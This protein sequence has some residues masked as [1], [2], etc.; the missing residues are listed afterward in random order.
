MLI[1]HQG[2][3]QVID[4]KIDILVQQY[5]QF[6]ISEDESIDGAFARFNTII[7]SLKA[8][9]EG[10]SSKNCVRKFLWA[11]HPKWRAKVTAIEESKS[12]ALKA[13]KES[14]DEVCSTS[15]SEDE[16]YAIAC[17]DPNHLIGECLKPLKDKNQRAFIGGSW[18]DSGEEDDEKIKDETCLVAQAPSETPKFGW[19]S[20]KEQRIQSQNL[21]IT[22]LKNRVKTLEDNEKTREGFAQEDAPNTG[23]GGVDQGEDLIVVNVE[24][25]NEKSTEKGSDSKDEMTN[26]LSTLGAANVLSSGITASATAGV[27]TA[28]GKLEAKFAQEDQIIRKQVERD[29]EIAKIHAERELEMMIAKLDRRNEMV[30]KYLCE[31]QQAEAEFSHDEKVEL[32]NKLLEYQ[33]NLAQIRKYQAQQSKLATKAERRKFYMSVLRS[34]AGW[35][36]KD[37]KGMTFEQIEEKFIPVWEKIQDF[38]PMNSKLEN[39]RVKRPGSQLV[40]ES[41]KKLKTAKASSSEPSQEQQTKEPKELSEEEL[42]KMMEIIHVEEFYIEAL[43]AKYPIIDW[44]IYSEGQRKYW[45]IIRSLVKKTFST[46]DPT[47]DKEKE[48]W[49]ELKRLYEPNPRDQL[50]ALQ[51][52]MHDPLEWRLYDTCGVHHVSTRRGHEIFMLVE[53]DYPLKKGL[54]TVMLCNKLQVDHYSEMANELLMKIYSIAN[55]LR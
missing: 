27:A 32:I 38:V 9:D 44:E 23:G 45:K 3:S 53:K 24:I 50:W 12:L 52:Y 19:V 39:E 30:A 41:S 25:N 48:L 37:F 31:Y 6:V 26:V 5:E 1:T 28:S 33:R 14:S 22:Q 29:S 51:K 13:K 4:N 10:Y 35:K 15:R 49:V 36:V 21:E 7:T 18:S 46:T 2:N 8:L 47:E 34:N 11:L 42:K 20:L 17:G 54:T 43:Q 55:S 40:Q 16:E